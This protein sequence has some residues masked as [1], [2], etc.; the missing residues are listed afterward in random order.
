PG[1]TD[2]IWGGYGRSHDLMTRGAVATVME[3][4]E[5]I[6]LPAGVVTSQDHHSRCK[7][8]GT[9][10]CRVKVTHVFSG[11][12]AVPFLEKR[13][14]ATRRYRKACLVDFMKE[15]ES[16]F[17][18]VVPFCMLRP[19]DESG[20]VRSF[21]GVAPK[22]HPTVATA[23]M[24]MPAIP[25]AAQLAESLAR[26]END[27]EVGDRRDLDPT[28]NLIGRQEPG[29][30]EFLGG[31]EPNQNESSVN[32]AEGEDTGATNEGEGEDTAAT[33]EGGGEESAVTNEG[34]GEES[35]VTNEGEE[36]A[37]TRRVL[38]E[39]AATVPTAASLI[40]I[41]TARDMSEKAITE[42][43]MDSL[44]YDLNKLEKLDRSVP[45][46]YKVVLGDGFHFLQRIWTPMHHEFKKAFCYALMNAVYQWDPND[47]DR[48]R[49][50]LTSKGWTND[51]FESI[52]FYRP[53]YFRTRVK[54]I[55][56]PPNKLYYRVRAVFV[57]FGDKIDSKT[58]KAL[59]NAEGW[60]SANSMLKEVRRGFYSDPP[61][62]NFYGKK[63]DDKGDLKSD[64]YGNQ[65]ITC[66]RG[67]NMVESVHKNYNWT[68]HHITG[69][70]MGDAKL[71]ERRHRHNWDRC[72]RIYADF[73]RCGHYDV[74]KLEIVQKLVQ[75]NWGFNFFSNFSCVGDY[76][77]TE[78]SFITVPLHDKTLDDALRKKA[79][80]LR[81]DKRV[82][83]K[84]FDDLA[85]VSRRWNVPIPFLP[86]SQ[87][88]E[89]KL[90]TDLM[91]ETDKSFDENAMALR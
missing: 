35:A 13:G 28:V 87:K 82:T 30:A 17:E 14:P 62:W 64:S 78:E 79:G 20:A 51:D 42:G 2:Q 90:F 6:R 77:D 55:I 38:E 66:K 27:E 74:W 52:L 7:A 61:G 19:H 68:F 33:N 53:S 47:L 22:I 69:V 45:V 34:E 46:A 3:P 26:T 12:L 15:D 49:A 60:K 73:P 16:P 25:Q 91:I 1:D 39:D 86:V 48:V 41:Q 88:K 76:A 24:T 83:K 4:H 10:T 5:T 58:K 50:N 84:A 56:L 44:E 8:N 31:S 18:I 11:F 89:F 70:E 59:F 40:A 21:L 75:Q 81:V 57:T 36:S 9:T 23:R 54:R 72:K 43:D 80:E 32:E 85:F 37:A 65:L 71:A 67:T 29:M 63:L